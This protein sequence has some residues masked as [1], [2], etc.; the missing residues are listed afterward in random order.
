MMDN[1]SSIITNKEL[2]DLINGDAEPKT[3]AMIHQLV[4]MEHSEFSSMLPNTTAVAG[5]FKGIGNFIPLEMKQTLSNLLND[6][7]AAPA[8]APTDFN[9]SVRPCLS[10]CPTQS[11]LEAFESI[12]CS[13]LKSVDSTITDDQCAE[14]IG[15]VKDQ[16]IDDLA[17]L[18]DAAQKGFLNAAPGADASSI[19]GDAC[20]SILPNPESSE[21]ALTMAEEVS[22]EEAASSRDFLAQELIGWRGVLNY[23]LSDTNGVPYTRHRFRAKVSPFYA[24]IYNQSLLQSFFEK[25]GDGDLVKGYFP[26]TVAIWLQNKLYEMA[27]DDTTIFTNTLLSETTSYTDPTTGET[28]TTS[29]IKASDVTF[30]FRDN[31]ASSAGSLV[32][33]FPDIGADDSSTFSYGFDIKYA[34]CPLEFSAG[35]MPSAHIK[36]VEISDELL[37]QQKTTTSEFDSAPSGV[38]P[39][40]SLM[41]GGIED[42]L[43]RFPADW[44]VDGSRV[45][46]YTVLSSED[47]SYSPQVQLFYQIVRDA[48]SDASYSAATTSDSFKTQ[49]ASDYNNQYNSLISSLS[50]AISDNESA[51][52][53]GYEYEDIDRWSGDLDYVSGLDDAGERIPYDSELLPEEAKVL[54]QSVHERVHF[55]DPEKYGGKYSK[56]RFYISPKQ[57]NGW[58]GIAEALVPEGD[59]T[60]PKRAAD[61]L[62]LE[63]IKDSVDDLFRNLPSDPRVLLGPNAVEVPFAR[64]M[65]RNAVASIQGNI[66]TTL[67]TFI[68]EELIKGV[69]IFNK[70]QLPGCYDDVYIDYIISKLEEELKEQGRNRLTGKKD[71]QY[72][73]AFLEQCV[74]MIGQQ[75]ADESITPSPELKGAIDEL[76]DVQESYS[77]ACSSLDLQS[78]VDKEEEIFGNKI[79]NSYLTSKKG[80]KKYRDLKQLESVQSVENTAKIVMKQLV[81]QEMSE[82]ADSYYDMLGASGTSSPEGNKYDLGPNISDIAKHFIGSSGMCLGSSLN[83]DLQDYTDPG[84]VWN[85]VSTIDESVLDNALPDLG[86]SDFTTLAL[87]ALGSDDPIQYIKEEFAETFSTINALYQMYTNDKPQF[88]LEKYV[89][90]EDPKKDIGIADTDYQHRGVVNLDTF[91]EFLDGLGDSVKEELVSDYFG[92]LSIIDAGILKYE[93][94]TSENAGHVHTYIMDSN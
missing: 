13:L 18:S 88:V 16:M 86:I 6:P 37:S 74:Q 34:E 83:I 56:P 63:Q 91:T 24:D 8:D 68:L 59:G 71:E 40:I 32:D 67:R 44:I 42:A 89:Y 2:V 29:P 82:V 87:A 64:I 90:V 43:N 4:S 51:F 28:T 85:V 21:E 9:P 79:T 94:E 73:Y 45:P 10:I 58:L 22:S 75:V 72:W 65:D 54:G 80:L 46:R 81:R 19:I 57:K 35:Q 7:I 60:E 53:F 61:L 52:L 76:N 84:D 26:E 39:L 36:V 66:R 55:L 93:G 25:L 48:W 50:T 62:G 69:P 14:Q 27:D 49:A 11:Q 3:L 38:D 31:N 30:E 17:S 15:K 78:A 20:D 5:L 77:F 1:V 47:S 33:I 92:D 70:F 12:R 23:I 41:I